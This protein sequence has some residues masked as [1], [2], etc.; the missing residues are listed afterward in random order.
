MVNPYSM[1]YM[2]IHYYFWWIIWGCVQIKWRPKINRFF[3]GG[4]YK[5]KFSLEVAYTGSVQV[6]ECVSRFL[7]A[8]KLCLNASRRPY[9]TAEL[10]VIHV[11]WPISSHAFSNHSILLKAKLTHEVTWY[12][13]VWVI[14]VKPYLC[15]YM[16]YISEH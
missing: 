7:L 15:L 8:Q 14:R 16:K 12:F 5:N 9:P 10:N 3:L 2:G 1:L 13:L 6:L 11:Y 4:G